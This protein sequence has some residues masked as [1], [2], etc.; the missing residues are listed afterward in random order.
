MLG[1]LGLLLPLL[2]ILYKEKGISG[3]MG[4]NLKTKK[5]LLSTERRDYIYI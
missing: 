3:I 2:R 1:V 4:N 5:S